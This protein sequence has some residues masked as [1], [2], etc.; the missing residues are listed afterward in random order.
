MEQTI[1]PLK[2]GTE[3]REALDN[4]WRPVVAAVVS[5][6]A[7]VWQR[8]RTVFWSVRDGLSSEIAKPIDIARISAHL[9]VVRRAEEEGRHNLPPTTEET[10]SGTQ[11]EIIAYF[12]NLRRR[13][14]KQVAE[15]AEKSRRMLEKIR[16]SDTVA[17]LQDIPSA[18]ENKILRHIADSDKHFLNAIEREQKQKRH[19]EAFREKH[20]L[21]RVA[22]Y[23]GVVVPYFLSVPVL[24]V[25][26]AFA[27]VRIIEASAGSEISASLGWIVPVAA[28][29]VIVP[30]VIGDVWL[31]SI[32]HVRRFSRVFGLVGAATAITVILGMAFYID[33]HIASVLA[34]PETSN[35]DILDAMIA[36]PFHGAATVANWKVFSLIAL[37]GLF[38]M[39]LAYRSDDPY[40]GYGAVQR[41]YYAA[42]EAREE[43][44]A[45]LRRWANSLV[46]SAEAEI[47]AVAREFKNKVRAYTG[48][49]EKSKQVPVA[50]K[51]YDAELEDACN[52][53]LDRYR[54]ANISSRQSD[55]P[56]SF[57]EHVCFNPYNE[58]ECDS[59]L[60][61]N[62][63]VAELQ[64]AIAELDK[65][66]ALARQKL[67]SLNVRM[68]DSIS[69]PQ[70][71]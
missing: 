33:F 29:S 26:I 64:D 32:N 8:I 20:G 44:S 23:P 27:L 36:A 53:V 63:H 1:A 52:L 16:L 61:S 42:R 5:F 43:A 12:M 4:V 31:R 35:R 11:R 2:S 28:A 46:D 41:T 57:S 30:F 9:G 71:A 7:T 65:E 55:A 59:L 38:S 49:V 22:S 3:S 67:R 54:V 69:D 25:I 6:L 21:D 58:I 45:R 50:L 62:G 17:R 56:M 13:A 60:E 70:S 24:I 18:C 34:N 37:S 39:L 19:Y 47:D 68:I 40:P 51:D 15:A 14:R 10:P 48:S 66:A